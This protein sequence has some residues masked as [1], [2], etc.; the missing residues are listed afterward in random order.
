[1]NLQRRQLLQCGA[2]LL[3]AQGALCEPDYPAPPPRRRLALRNLHTE[4]VLDLDYCSG[5]AYLPDAMARIVWVLRDFRSGEQHEI[6]PGLLDGLSD[7]AAALRVDP[8]F[9]VISGYRSAQTNEMLRSQSS[10]VALRSLHMDG[11]AIDVRLAGIGCDDLAAGAL[12]LGRG[13]VGYYRRSDFVHLDTG[14]PRSWQ[15]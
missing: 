13:G 7:L 5:G 6:D 4:E 15:G 1:M 8:V 9:D 11:R 14:L 12:A 3:L 2:G 10:G